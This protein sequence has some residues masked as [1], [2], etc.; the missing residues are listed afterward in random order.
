MLNLE[1][2][3]SVGSV[4]PL[5]LSPRNC[6]SVTYII[7]Y[8][9]NNAG[10]VQLLGTQLSSKGLAQRVHSAME[11]SRLGFRVHTL[12]CYSAVSGASYNCHHAGLFQGCRLQAN[13]HS[14]SQG[15]ASG[16][17]SSSPSFLWAQGQT[18]LQKQEGEIYNFCWR[19]VTTVMGF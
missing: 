14:L 3:L 10:W 12:T 6:L 16:S 19:A 9:H 8:R 5:A 7:L 13:L 18:I 2:L 1:N 4:L 11:S 17:W 15:E